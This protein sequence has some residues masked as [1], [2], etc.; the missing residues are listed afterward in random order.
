MEGNMKNFADPAFL[1]GA[2]G[3]ITG[4]FVLFHLLVI[5]GIVPD[6]I[7]WGGRYT[8]RRQIVTMEA[9]SL[10]LIVLIGSLSFLHGRMTAAGNGTMLLRVF[11]WIFAA[12]FLLNTVGNIFAKTAFERYAFT[13]VTALLSFLTLRLALIGV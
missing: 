7:V 9:V 10:V 11:M 6:T 2:I 12:V 5:A 3:V 4:V 13:P 8:D 1:G